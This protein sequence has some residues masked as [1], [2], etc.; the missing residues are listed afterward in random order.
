MSGTNCKHQ[1]GVSLLQKLCKDE[2]S[3]FVFSPLSLGTAFAML[4]AGLKGDTKEE[5]L[6]FL[7]CKNETALHEMYASVLANKDLPLKIANKY[8]AQDKV[9]VLKDFDE[10]LKTKYQSEVETVDFVANGRAVEQKINSW[11]AEKT[12]NMIKTLLPANSLTPDTIMVLLNAVYFKGTWVQE[13]QPVPGKLDFTLKD[14]T[15]VKKDFMT[16]TSK[17][18]HYSETDKLRLVKIPYNEAKCYMIVALP[19]DGTK[20]ID[21]VLQQMSPADMATAIKNLESGGGLPV[22]L[23]MPKFKIEYSFETVKSHMQQLGVDKIFKA[24]VGDFSNMFSNSEDLA[25]H[26]STIFHR[27]VVEVDERGTKA[28]AATAIVM[29]KRMSLGRLP[30][31]NIVVV[32]NRPFHFQILC[33][34]SVAFAGI[35]RGPM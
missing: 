16:K 31:E 1:L 28:A 18:F 13:F 17:K 20:H 25:S 19:I 21:D 6:Q 29:N 27:A 33:A 3:N 7:G 26:V 8:V 22:D 4:A 14:G 32:L 35:C 10:F 23:T 2:K 15:I 5:L 24:G 11:V 12:N 30:P 34:D 9:T